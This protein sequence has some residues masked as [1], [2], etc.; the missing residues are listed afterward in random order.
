MK[1]HLHSAALLILLAADFRIRHVHQAHSVSH[2]F[3]E[4]TSDI[5]YVKV[6][7]LAFLPATSCVETK[8]ELESMILHMPAVPE[9]LAALAIG[10]SR[11][12]S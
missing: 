9:P 5:V 12:A 4:N 7:N 1:T 2:G 3:D 11:E 10:I 8:A 6:Q